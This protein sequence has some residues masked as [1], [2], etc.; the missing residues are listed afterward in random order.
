MFCLSAVLRPGEEATLDLPARVR[1]TPKW[2][3]LHPHKAFSVVH[4]NISAGPSVKAEYCLH[5]NE[6]LEAGSCIAWGA[7]SGLLLKGMPRVETKSPFEPAFLDV[8]TSAKGLAGKHATVAVTEGR[9]A[10]GAFLSS[11]TSSSFLL[12]FLQVCGVS[13]CESSLIGQAVNI[14][15]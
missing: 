4:V 14:K 6:S 5:Q 2:R 7:K 8:N 3:I 10:V 9:F 1:I 11:L 13:F 12:L 15:W